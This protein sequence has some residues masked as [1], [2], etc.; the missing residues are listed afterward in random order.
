VASTIDPAADP[1]E[2]VGRLVSPP[3]LR[4][5]RLFIAFARQ[6]VKVQTVYLAAYWMTLANL[7]VKLTA[8]YLLWRVLYRQD[9]HAFP[10]SGRRMVTY[11]VMGVLMGQVLT[12]WDGPHFYV[13]E[14]VKQGTIG[15]EL[16]RPVYFPF[17]VFARTVGQTLATAVT[18]VLPVAIVAFVLLRLALPARASTA[19]WFV[20]SLGLGYVIL[21]ALNF[22]VGCLTF[23]TLT[24]RGVQ[25]AYH[26]VITLLSGLWIPLWFYPHWLRQVAELLPFQG[27]FFTPLALYV[28]QID[29]SAASAVGR[30]A[31]WAA[32]LVVAAGAGWAAVERRLV[33]QGG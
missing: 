12:W 9:P 27:I 30:Q 26:G 1:T 33:V 2:L 31:L 4:A 15:S 3:W 17:H 13:W 24:L 5:G 6:G 28:G 7:V 21:F 29:G 10:L 32:I 23:V 8:M 11:A 22:L 25:H 14:R 16:V 18:I 20:L 19:G